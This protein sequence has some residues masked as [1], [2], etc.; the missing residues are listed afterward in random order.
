M[1]NK[2]TTT[3]QTNM[4]KQIYEN[5]NKSLKTSPQPKQQMT[6]NENK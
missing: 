4:T 3:K 6:T 1:S 5:I 2:Q